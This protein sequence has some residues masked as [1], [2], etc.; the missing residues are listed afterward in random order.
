MIEL[1]VA[2]ILATTARQPCD[3]ATECQTNLQPYVEFV[4]RDHP[5]VTPDEAWSVILCESSG[6]PS[7]KNP[8]STAGGV[9]QYLEGTWHGEAHYF[10]W[11]LTDPVHRFDPV[12]AVKLTYLV[13]ERDAITRG[14]PFSQWSCKP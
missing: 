12:L 5:Y 2:A 11:V 14:N 3:T 10:G 7:A 6:K 1:I 8:H 4:F 13:T 9:A